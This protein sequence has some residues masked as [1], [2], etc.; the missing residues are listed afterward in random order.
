M[1]NMDSLSRT[2]SE[3]VIETKCDNKRC[4][5]SITVV[6]FVNRLQCKTNRNGTRVYFNAIEP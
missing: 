3:N 2:P 4:Y 6:V 5:C 1:L